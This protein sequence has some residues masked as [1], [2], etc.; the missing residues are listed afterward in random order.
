MSRKPFY[1]T[2]L[3]YYV[4]DKPHLGHAYTTV[5]TM[6][7]RLEER[8]LVSHR[9]EGRTFVYHPRLHFPRGYGGLGE[10]GF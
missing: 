5:A 2:T 4:N 10:E 1:V 6:L 8:R 9:E 3:I 7:R